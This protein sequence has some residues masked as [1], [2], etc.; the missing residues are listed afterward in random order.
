M[1]TGTE[2]VS[3]L[4]PD[5]PSTSSGRN[6]LGQDAFLKLM[7]TQLK[8]QDPMKPTESGEFLS[9]LAQFSAVTGIEKLN[10]SFASLSESLTA[11]RTLQAAQLVG[12]SVMLPGDQLELDPASDSQLSAAI[13]LPEIVPDLSVNIYDGVGQLVRSMNIEG[14]GPGLVDV[15]WDGLGDAGEPLPAGRYRVEAIGTLDGE[16]TVFESFVPRGVEGV[17]LD[18]GNQTPRLLLADGEAIGLDQVREIR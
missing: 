16:A 2:S 9:Q 6:T 17:S 12:R 14:Q 15:Q 13:D 11:N 5:A 18:P 4:G 1:I 8:A 3:S 10:N 7:M